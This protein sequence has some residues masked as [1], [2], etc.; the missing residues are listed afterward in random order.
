MSKKKRKRRKEK[1]R[2]RR[3]EKKRKREENGR[4]TYFF[5]LSLSF[6]LILNEKLVEMRKIRVIRMIES[7]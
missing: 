1:K 6:T 2:E 5:T 7:D 3:K 4:N